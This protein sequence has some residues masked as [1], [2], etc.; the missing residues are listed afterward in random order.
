M[1]PEIKKLIG[2]GRCRPIEEN[3]VTS[4]QLVRYINSNGRER[5]A[6]AQYFEEKQ[7]TAFDADCGEY[8]EE[9]DE[10]YCNAGW[11]VDVPDAA[12][13]DFSFC[14]IDEQPSHFRPLP[15][16]RLADAL[17]V[18]VEALEWIFGYDGNQ[19]TTRKAEEALTKIKQISERKE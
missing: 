5:Y 18:A 1:T 10:Y 17:E 6:L 8:D 9:E 2:D 12:G 15:D 3:K 7:L 16:N 19:H 13:C 4:K 11:Y 14:P